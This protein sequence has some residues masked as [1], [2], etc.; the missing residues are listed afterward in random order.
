[1]QKG[2]RGD[3][4]GSRSEPERASTAEHDAKAANRRFAG[5][6]WG[7]LPTVESCGFE[8]DTGETRAQAILRTEDPAKQG[9]GSERA[10]FGCQRSAG[11]A[12]NALRSAT[13]TSEGSGAMKAVSGASLSAQAQRSTTR[14]KP[15]RKPKAKGAGRYADRH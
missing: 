4:S 9:F 10:S 7:R 1:M 2:G 15:A 11:R 3:E 5:L 6:P 8:R 14:A 12:S 13:A